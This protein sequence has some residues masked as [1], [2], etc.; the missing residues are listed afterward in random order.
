VVVN[1]VARLLSDKSSMVREA[2][3][4]TLGNLGDPS[5]VPALVA[6]LSDSD[7]FVRIAAI[8]ALSKINDSSAGDP[9]VKM[10]RD[11]DSMVR[12]FAAGA[13]GQIAYPGAVPNLI[14]LLHDTDGPYWEEK[15]VCDVAADALHTI[16]TPEAARA[17]TEWRSTQPIKN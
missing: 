6:A 8:V 17:V 13:L 1:D 16:G 15:R 10:L 3:A 12:C 4:E 5:G 2:A 11:P 9:L 7:K 14:M